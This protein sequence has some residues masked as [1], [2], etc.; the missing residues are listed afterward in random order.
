M[1]LRIS[2]SISLFA[3]TTLAFANYAPIKSAPIT[4]PAKLYVSIF[5]GGGASNSFN[6][7]QF[8]TA[9]FLEA[10]G[11]PLSVDA[12]GRIDSQNTLFFGA[13]LG[14]QTQATPL[15]FSSQWSLTPGAELE[16]Y[17]MN[18]RSFN[19]T[20]INNTD[21]LPEHDFHVSYPMRR[22]VFLANAVLNFNNPCV[23]VHPYIGLGIGNA[24][25][26]ISG[27]NATQANPPEAGI[28]HYNKSTS[29]TNS[30]FA[31]QLKLGLSYNI[32]ERT[33]IFAEYRWLYLANTHFVLGSTAY[34]EH[35]PTSSW[36][37]NVNAQRYNLGSV[38]IRF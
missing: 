37:V 9:Y 14:Y 12:F 20:L 38:G 34:P 15:N 10:S 28:N 1:R 32:T 19:G 33:S 13:Q 26:R 36:Q 17:Y 6:G 23:L 31:G 18:K 35:V 24:I 3:L 16:G 25:V 22:T 8:A 21:R 5:G 30:T 11:G 7:N 4:S 27:A 29:D 2:S